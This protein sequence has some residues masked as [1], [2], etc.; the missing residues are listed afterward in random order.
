MGRFREVRQFVSKHTAIIY[1]AR[2][3]NLRARTPYTTLPFFTAAVINVHCLGI[4][5]IEDIHY[6]FHY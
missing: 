6:I 3:S 5:Q 4:R 1:G 2:Q